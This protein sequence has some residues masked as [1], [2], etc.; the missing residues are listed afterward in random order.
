M[1]CTTAI[2]LDPGDARC[3]CASET[4]KRSAPQARAP[5]QAREA[6]RTQAA[7]PGRPF[8][9][10]LRLAAGLAG[11]PLAQSLAMSS[12]V[13]SDSPQHIATAMWAIAMEGGC[14][15]PASDC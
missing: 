7:L 6:A 2:D 3:A 10:K 15:R 4:P 8:C 1:D 14:C 11:Q 13:Q 12:V 5:L 9:P